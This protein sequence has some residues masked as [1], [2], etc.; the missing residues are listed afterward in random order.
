MFVITA[1][2][3]ILKKFEENARLIII[4][5]IIQELFMRLSKELT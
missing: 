2:F 1:V 5:T 4:S 3:F